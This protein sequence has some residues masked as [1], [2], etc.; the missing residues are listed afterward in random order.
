MKRARVMVDGIVHNAT[1]A[2]GQVL[3]EDGRRFWQDQ[4]RW[5]PPLAPQARPRTIRRWASTTPTTP[6]SSPSRRRP[7]SRWYS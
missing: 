6:R 4:V 3:L 7:R 2:D 5:L 1:E